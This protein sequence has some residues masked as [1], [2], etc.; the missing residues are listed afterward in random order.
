MRPRSVIEE[1][2]LAILQHLARSAP[3]G[4]FVEVG[5]YQGGSASLLLDIARE[6]GRTLHLFDTFT[7]IP[8]ADPID[9]YRGGEFAAVDLSY[10]MMSMPDAVFHV[11]IF[12]Q[13]LPYDLADIAFVHVD[14]DQYASYRACIDCL[15]PRMVEGGIMVFD[16]YPF[17]LG[18][19][20]A[21]RESFTEAQLI[22]TGR[23]SHV[24]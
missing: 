11:G 12:P 7:G 8:G 10:L 4:C 15:Y 6:Q 19:R 18:A 24:V 22:D 3:P 9:R 1:P 21:V 17:L 23:R 13:T 14:C 20:Q 2:Q 5:V 16:D